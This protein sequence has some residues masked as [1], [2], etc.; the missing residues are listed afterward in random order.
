MTTGGRFLT[1]GSVYELLEL[2]YQGPT[3]PRAFAAGGYDTALFSGERLDGENMAAFMRNAGYRTFYDFAEDRAHHT[4]ETMISLL[5][6]AGGIHDRADRPLARCPRPRVAGSVLPELSDRRH[7]SPLW[8]SRRL[9][10][11]VPREGRLLALP[12]RT[13]LHRR[14]HRQTARCAGRARLAG[15]DDRRQSPGT[16]ARPSARRTRRTSLTGTGS[17]RRTSKAS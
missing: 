1:W 3:L 17:T 8:R 2:N 16:T 12:Q 11:P 14:G 13:A 4:K 15:R 5:G 7:A 10:R 6:R 9:Q